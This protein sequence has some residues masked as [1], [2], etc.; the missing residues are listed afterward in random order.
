MT[1]STSLTRRQFSR[2]ALGATGALAIGLRAPAVLSQTTLK[3]GILLPR[4]GFFAQQ[5]Q[6]CQRGADI[7]AKLLAEMGYRIEMLSA[8]TESNADVARSRAEK[9]IGEGAQLLIGA[10]DS[11]NTAAIAQVAEQHGVPLVINIA[12]APQLTQQGY[13]T[14]F[15][16]FPT[17]MTLVGKGLALMKDLFQ[18]AHKSPATAIIMYAND[19]FGQANKAALDALLP[20]L[21][22][23]FKVLQSISYDPK[24]QD[25]SVEVAKAKA[26]GAELMI[27]NTRASDAIMLIREMVKQRYEPLGVISPG[28]PGFYDQQF[29]DVLGRYSD[30]II[31]N[32]PWINPR[33]ELAA[34]VAAAFKKQFPADRYASHAFN[35]GFTFEAILV[36]ADAA[37]RA[38]T[39]D[40][41]ALLQALAQT[42]LAEHVMIGEPI[43][44]DAKGQN[45]GVGTAAIQNR[46]TMPSVVLPKTLAQLEPVFPMPGWQHRT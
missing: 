17:S 7:A 39:T 6:S 38:G 44:F 41:K 16:N 14:V 45:D 23:P 10:F 31:S 40:P 35:V 34:R 21:N 2:V 4:S 22:M 18:V 33:S 25:L 9:L 27:A 30:Y 5:G 46:N 1:R 24:A 12:S 43:Q 42:H 20:P 19:T 32:V 28:S 13:R 29:Y 36:A 37:K 8:D 11:G 15:R 26:S 3:I